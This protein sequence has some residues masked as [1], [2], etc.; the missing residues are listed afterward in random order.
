MSDLLQRLPEPNNILHGNAIVKFCHVIACCHLISDNTKISRGRT[1][2]SNGELVTPLEHTTSSLLSNMDD[3]AS[4]QFNDIKSPSSSM[5]LSSDMRNATND[6]PSLP[7]ISEESVKV[8][9]ASS[10]IPER[11]QKFP[12]ENITE[13]DMVKAKI[14]AS[15]I[16][17]S[18][19]PNFERSAQSQVSQ[20]ENINQVDR[21]KDQIYNKGSPEELSS[22]SNT[23]VLEDNANMD[24]ERKGNEQFVMKNEF[25]ENELVNDISDNDS[26]GKGKL[27]NAAP[28]LSKRSHRYPTTILMNGKAE[29][30]RTENFPLHSAESYGQFSQS[31]TKDQAEEINTSNDVHNGIASHEDIRAND[32]FP[33]AK[34][35]LKAEVEPNDKT[36]L[37]A[38]VEI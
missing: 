19:Q 17:S 35:E 5:A 36:E 38:E 4:T 1:K 13:D 21:R 3:D 7:K 33:G 34:T 37:K 28:V 31:Q 10:K 18:T 11:I 27:N 9:D 24:E 15:Y 30:V 6:K 14:S 22:A 12:A 16:S 23:V 26:S 20:E 2:G 29:D 8:A 25:S 32:I